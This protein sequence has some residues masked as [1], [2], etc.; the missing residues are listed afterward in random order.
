[1]YM[2]TALRCT[3][4]SRAT[5]GSMVA[6]GNMVFSSATVGSTVR[7][8]SSI[9]SSS[10]HANRYIAKYSPS[11]IRWLRVSWVVNLAF[12]I[13]SVRVV[14]G[15]FSA[16][17]GP[18]GMFA[19]LTSAGS[20]SWQRGSVWTGCVTIASDTSAKRLAGVVARV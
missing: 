6:E 10:D 2:T 19:S 9:H 15:S 12:V 3:S 7:P 14:G 11:D 18:N 4:A 20:R 5:S 17:Y 16:S 1:M 13:G 8:R